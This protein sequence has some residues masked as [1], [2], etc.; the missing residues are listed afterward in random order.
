MKIDELLHRISSEAGCTISPP[1]GIPAVLPGHAIPDDVLA[2]YR[3][4]GGASLFPGSD[5]EYNI[6]P[7][8][9][10]RP[11]NAVMK[12]DSGE[13]DISDA[14]YVIADDRGGDYLSIDFDPT[15]LGR[16]YDSFHE[17]HGMVGD[18]PIIARS[19]SELLERLL[20]NRGS[21]PYW[22]RDDFQPIGDAYDGME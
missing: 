11:A 9:E 19:F 15:R 18:T 22:L 20:E 2:F 5:Y 7:P 3:V 4:A 21:Y 6:L 10:V 14:W 1:S 17:T 12:I 16:C 13:G 8:G